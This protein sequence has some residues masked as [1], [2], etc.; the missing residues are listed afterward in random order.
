MTID[1]IGSV[2][3]TNHQTDDQPQMKN[4]RPS[5]S[6][7]L[8]PFLVLLSAYCF[9]KLPFIGSID[10]YF[11]TTASF[12]NFDHKVKMVDELE[13]YLK[14]PNHR[15]A[16]VL[17]GNSRTLSFSR[18]YIEE[19]YP[20]WT[21]FNFSVPGGT[22]D[23][24]YYLMK[25]FKRRHIRPDAIYFAV[26]PQGMNQSAAIALDE[27]MVFGLPPSFLLTEFYHYKVDDLTNYIAKKAFLVYRY[28]PKLRIIEYR[29]TEN[30]SG[31][32][33]VEDFRNLLANT[34]IS[35]EKERG[36]VPYDLDIKPAQDL[37][38][39]HQNAVSIW[40]D[41]FVPFQLD[42]DQV[43]FTEKSLEI[44]KQLG[45]RTGLLW[46]KV[47]TEL[48]QYKETEK[49]TKN[50]QTVRQV[51]ESEMI[52]IT[53]NQK[54]DWLDFNYNKKYDIGCDLFFDASHMASGCF[55]PFMDA[56]MKEAM[57]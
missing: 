25:Q 32:R 8:F 24:F 36:S 9:D 48:R 13:E 41:A 23:Y 14:Q 51:F 50:G 37:E 17:F 20:D 22:T 42:A 57:Q 7:F 18:S 2:S 28:R 47:S 4:G 56:V 45:A 43:E 12:L 21:L 55:R 49:V 15:R 34:K 39:I 29:F 30:K 10:D 54:A 19:K 52:R 27:V 31:V 38:A 53:N 16:L 26:T 33:N 11:L 35:L 44:A 3:Q 5:L 40:Q 6:L 1:H 46:P